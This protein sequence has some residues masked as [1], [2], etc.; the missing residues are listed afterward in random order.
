MGIRFNY[1][2]GAGLIGAYAA[3]QGARQSRQQ[4]YALD[5]IERKKDREFKYQMMQPQLALGADR[6]R[7]LQQRI[8]QNWAQNMQWNPDPNQPGP[9]TPHQRVV[10]R[11]RA[12]KGLPP[13]FNDEPGGKWE[14]RP[15]QQQPLPPVPAL[16]HAP[17][18]GEQPGEQPGAQPDA[19]PG[20]Q[21]PG[22]LQLPK[23]LRG[24]D[25]PAELN[26]PQANIFRPPQQPQGNILADNGLETPEGL[27]HDR[28]L[29]YLE[30]L[31]T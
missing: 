17:L 1:Q 6:N 15:P 2:V 5:M 23:W 30:A 3:G 25:N 22:W 9:L 20:A 16:I 14:P 18:P 26:E 8:N 13:M 21:L 10:N 7:M 4:K 29:R 27:A 24:R 11:A 19:Q 12:R 31:Y 28:S